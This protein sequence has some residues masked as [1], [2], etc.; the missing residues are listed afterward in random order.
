MEMNVKVIL[1]ITIAGQFCAFGYDPNSITVT[2]PRYIDEGNASNKVKGLLETENG[3]DKILTLDFYAEIVGLKKFVQSQGT[4]MKTMQET[5][6]RLEETTKDQASKLDEKDQILN[7]YLLKQTEADNLIKEL[8]SEISGIN[9][10]VKTMEMEIGKLKE[11][12]RNKDIKMKAVEDELLGQKK[13]AEILEGIILQENSESM[14]N[15]Y[16][17]HPSSGNEEVLKQHGRNTSKVLKGDVLNYSNH[18]NPESYEN[19]QV[20]EERMSKRSNMKPRTAITRGVAF[21]T[22]LS[23]TLSHLG[24]GHT[25]KLDQVSLNDGNGYSVITGVFTAPQYGVYLL[26]FTIDV[27]GQDAKTEVR[28]VKNNV[29]IVDAIAWSTGQNH[30]V[31]GGNSAIIRLSQ[32]EMVWLENYHQVDS[33]IMSNPGYVF[34]TFSGVLLYS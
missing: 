34:T 5:I 22:Y 28:L 13:V 29:N 32:G 6:Y 33:Q 12:V 3:E 4:T 20:K 11:T 10:K 8:R 27:Y 14:R 24:N 25:I 17:D 26:M 1:A 31:M 19:N 18:R 9:G 2:T 7:H 15:N 16:W 21:S 30:D 23:K